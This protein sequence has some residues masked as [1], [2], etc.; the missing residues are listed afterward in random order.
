M[1]YKKQDLYKKAD[2]AVNG[3]WTRTAPQKIITSKP[4]A[5][6]ENAAPVVMTPTDASVEIPVP[7]SA[8]APGALP[9]ANPWPSTI[10]APPI[11]TLPPA[12]TP[13]TPPGKSQT[14]RPSADMTPPAG[15]VPADRECGYCITPAMSYTPRQ[16][17]TDVYEPE[18]GFS[19]GTIF[20]QL[21]LPFV[22]GKAGMRNE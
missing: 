12:G 11:S 1:E 8:T 3:G 7:V 14:T 13:S 15:S 5:M 22:G 4:A 18:S 16:E 17:W 9:E 6:P 20:A 21:D 2:Q 19:R 10:P